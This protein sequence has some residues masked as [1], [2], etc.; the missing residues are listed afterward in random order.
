MVYVSLSVTEVLMYVR[1]MP[2]EEITQA[3]PEARPV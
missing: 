1:G 2:M 3:V